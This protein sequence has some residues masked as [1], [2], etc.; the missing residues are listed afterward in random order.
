MVVD[1][2]DFSEGGAIYHGDCRHVL[3]R[4]PSGVF[5]LVFADPPY[6][7][8]NRSYGRMTE[9]DWHEMMQ[10]VIPQL[11]RVLKPQGSAVLILQP[12]S[13][14]LGS[15]RPWL[16]EYLVWC[17]RTW[18]V[19]QDAY[20]W[21]YAAL[22]EGHAIQGKLLRPSLKYCVWLGAPDCHRRQDQVLWTESQG[23]VARRLSLRLRGKR[24]YKP[25]GHGTDDYQAVRAALEAGGVTP[26]NVLPL[27]NTSS[28]GVNNKCNHGAMTPLELCDWW[29]RYLA[30]DRGL[31]LDPFAGTATT[32]VVAQRLG[33][34]F[35]GV[36]KEQGYFR[37]GLE[38]LQGD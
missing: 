5:D 37:A 33:L 19:V 22:P 13:R 21:N 7:E 24:N 3:P 20:W 16:W 28:G 15:M 2:D 23:N 31:I 6:P 9:A 17:C 34:R 30:P 1:V 8:V 14:A 27:P 38:R 12:N 11:R 25:S 36:E 29:L 18:N 32:G 26:F 35:V 4:L 10:E